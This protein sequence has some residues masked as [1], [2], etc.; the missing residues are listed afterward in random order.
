[1]VTLS[2]FIIIVQPLL[3]YQYKLLAEEPQVTNAKIETSFRFA[4]V[5]KPSWFTSPVNVFIETCPCLFS[6]LFPGLIMIKS[7]TEDANVGKEKA[8]ITFKLLHRQNQS[9]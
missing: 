6:P 3:T 9:L 2:I 1:M 7:D 8:E 4:S 5:V